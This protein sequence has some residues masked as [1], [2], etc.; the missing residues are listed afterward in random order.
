[1]TLEA[2]PHVPHVLAGEVIGELGRIIVCVPDGADAAAVWA[3]A[4]PA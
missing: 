4:G 3:V 2:L 1:M